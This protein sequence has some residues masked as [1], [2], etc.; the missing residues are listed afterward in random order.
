MRNTKHWADVR[1]SADLARQY[2]ERHLWRDSTPAA[3]LRRWATETPAAVAVTAQVSS[4]GV[5]RLTYRE[6]AEQVERVTG[7]LAGLGIGPG[8][9]VAIQLPSWWQLNAVVLA[10]ARLG[11]VVAPIT[12]MIRARE[13]ELMLAR[14]EPVA[15]VTTEV[16]A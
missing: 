6:Y 5:V 7:V 14:L 3:D 12:T 2:R 13:L 8:D 15:Y 16:W 11:A 10:C 9:V 1:P 4:T